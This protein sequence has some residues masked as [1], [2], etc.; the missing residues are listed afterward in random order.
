MKGDYDIGGPLKLNLESRVGSP[1]PGLRPRAETP[2]IGGVLTLK[3]EFELDV[4]KAER[5][6]LGSEFEVGKAISVKTD[7]L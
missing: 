4:L 5:R 1:Q 3:S 2:N 7:I 6:T